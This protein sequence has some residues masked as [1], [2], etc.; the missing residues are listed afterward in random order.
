MFKVVTIVT[1]KKKLTHNKKQQ[2]QQ[3]SSI[4]L[5]AALLPV[6]HNN[7]LR[8]LSGHLVFHPCPLLLF[9]FVMI[10]KQHTRKRLS[11]MQSAVEGVVVSSCEQRTDAHPDMFAH[12]ALTDAPSSMGVVMGTVVAPST[13]DHRRATT[14]LL[15]PKKMKAKS[16]ETSDSQCNSSCRGE[17]PS[18]GIIF[19]SHALQFDDSISTLAIRYG[20]T[21]DGI[22]KCNGLLTRDLDLLPKGCVLQIPRTHEKP[23]TSPPEMTAH[24]AAQSRHALEERDRLRRRV[25]R[26]FCTKHEGC[27]MDEATFYLEDH[28]YNLEDAT[29]A[30]NDDV[31]WE[32]SASGRQAKKQFRQQMENVRR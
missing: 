19:V 9:C 26:D 31:A 1:E 32:T 3:H 17:P 13:A 29:K 20:S 2:Q 21:V 16:D 10:T 22:M 18:Q 11:R 6:L 8:F 30:W 15:S 14:T 12:G 28:N 4:R 23:L 7:K 5:Y 27:T 25:V 24:S